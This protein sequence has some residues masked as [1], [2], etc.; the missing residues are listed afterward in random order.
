MEPTVGAIYV[1]S[2][3]PSSAAAL[4]LSDGYTFRIQGGARV[5]ID[6][7]VG[8]AHVTTVVTG[9]LFDDTIV[10]GNN[11]QGGTFGQS[12]DILSDQ[13]KVQAEAIASINFDFGHGVSASVQGDIYGS[14]DIF[15]AGGQVTL[16]MQ[17]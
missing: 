1:N 11:I 14:R 2:S 7:V 10:H 5:G 6:S 8:A 4:G 15:G 12:G 9:L 17:W 16:R 3:Y 13:G